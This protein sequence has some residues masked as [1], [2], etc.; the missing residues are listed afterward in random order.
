MAVTTQII[1]AQLVAH[2]EQ[3]V[4]QRWHRP[5]PEWFKRTAFPIALRRPQRER[6]RQGRMAV[7]AGNEAA[8]P[9][10]TISS[11]SAATASRS[12]ARCAE[13]RD[14]D[15][16]PATPRGC[17]SAGGT[18][19]QASCADARGGVGSRCR[20]PS[21]H[22]REGVATF[23]APGPGGHQPADVDLFERQGRRV[24]LGEVKPSTRREQPRRLSA[25][26]GG[27]PGS[28]MIAPK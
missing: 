25:P 2:D 20:S 18:P 17:R 28:Q 27:C 6:Q 8:L 23:G 14:E 4:S 24:S 22:R 19:L 12:R 26:S 9:A 5:F 13:S 1:E 3:N 15:R 21:R 11:E 10:G 7:Q 16:F